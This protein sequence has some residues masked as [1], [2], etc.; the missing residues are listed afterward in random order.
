MLNIIKKEVLTTNF[1]I[2]TYFPINCITRRTVICLSF[3]NLNILFTIGH[4]RN[5]LTRLTR[6]LLARNLIIIT[7]ATL[8]RRDHRSSIFIGCPR[9]C[10]VKSMTYAFIFI[11]VKRIIYTYRITHFDDLICHPLFPL[12]VRIGLKFITVG[13]C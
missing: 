9:F 13:I 8:S 5:L 3:D 10:N 2:S 4:T 12:A 7:S 11:C 1:P 6:S